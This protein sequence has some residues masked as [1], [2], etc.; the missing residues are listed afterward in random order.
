[1]SNKIA[2]SG[3]LALVSLPDIFQILGSNNATG[4]LK[5]T[6]N[7]TPNPGIIHFSNGNPINAV[8]GSSKG[9]KALYSMFGWQEGEYLFYEE[10]VRSVQVTIKKSRMDIVLD[11]L[12]LLDS[13][14]IKK[15]GSNSSLALHPADKV[16]RSGMPV[17]K[18]PLTDYLYVVREDFFKDGQAIVKEGRH[19]KWIWSVYEGVVRITRETPKGPLV[20][21][22]IGEGCFIGT[23]RALLYGEYERNA[24]V[25]A[26]GDLRLCMLDAEPF[27]REYSKLSPG[28]RRLLLS[29]DQRLRKLN[30]RAIEIFSE[31]TAAEAK[32]SKDSANNK[33]FDT[34]DDLYMIVEGSV[35]VVVKDHGGRN[36]MFSLDNNDVFGNIPFVDFGHEPNSAII[37]ASRD[38]KTEKL[39]V[40]EIQNEYDK[41]SRTFKNLIYNICNYIRNTTGLVN[42][43][44]EKN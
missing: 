44:S 10:D 36:I 11:A 30:M 7:Y 40:V 26:E 5:L 42:R 35:T 3:S 16:D 32:L 1:M 9:P 27:Y 39:D 29:L 31:D 20:L 18:G 23:I 4:I 28:F 6:S 33:I 14:K 25:I 34:G 43:L 38:L 8:H 24:S 21:A 22:R 41:L 2:I 19:G 17:L 15:I 37:T 13:D 12:S